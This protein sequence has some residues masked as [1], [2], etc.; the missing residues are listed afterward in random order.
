MKTF[1]SLFVLFFLLTVAISAAQSK[2]N[3]DCKIL[4]NIKLK[5][6]DNPDHYHDFLL[7]PDI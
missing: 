7:S 2:P 4:K 6:V 3:F 1:Q 5:Y